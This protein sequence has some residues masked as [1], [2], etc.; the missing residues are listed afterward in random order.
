VIQRFEIDKNIITLQ[1]CNFLTVVGALEPIWML[2]QSKAKQSEK[3][4]YILY[5]QA[6]QSKYKNAQAKAAEAVEAFS[7]IT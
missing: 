6:K 7:S 5:M 3:N 2:K 1:E 4:F